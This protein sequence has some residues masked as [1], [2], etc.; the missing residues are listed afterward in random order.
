MK[1]ILLKLAPVLSILA[2]SLIVARYT[3]LY[4]IYSVPTPANEPGLHAGQWKLTFFW[5][6][7]QPGDFVVFKR[8][9]DLFGPEEGVY[10]FRW[11][12]SAGDTVEMRAGD[13]YVNGVN[14]DLGKR[15]G[16]TYLITQE[17]LQQ[18]HQD[19]LLTKVYPAPSYGPEMRG[20]FT[21]DITRSYASSQDLED[22]R[23]LQSNGTY[24]E[25]FFDDYPKEWGTDFFG[26]YVVPN[27]HIF[28][29]GDNRSSALDSRLIGPIPQEEIIDVLW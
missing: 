27:H 12:A 19:S 13:F 5:K 2:C 21:V 10:V 3:G 16:A 4:G 7:A 26:P 29:L 18:L 20:K 11:C 22:N 23:F 8:Q 28:V 1:K 25:K 15:L 14:Q 24:E 9:I 6:T 17:Q